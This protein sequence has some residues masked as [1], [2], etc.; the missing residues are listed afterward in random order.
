MGELEEGLRH[1]KHA[2]KLNPDNF[3]IINSLAD[4]YMLQGQYDSALVAISNMME[5]ESPHSAKIMG[6][7]EAIE[8]AAY[9][10]K[11]REALGLIE[12]LKELYLDDHD[13][14]HVAILNLIEGHIILNG[15]KDA[16]RVKEVIERNRQF[17]ES[18]TDSDYWRNLSVLCIFIGE[19]AA[20][21]R[22]L[23]NLSDSE[24]DEWEI[25]VHFFTSAKNQECARAD[26]HMVKLKHPPDGQWIIVPFVLAQCHVE[27][28]SFEEA[29]ELLH[30]VQATPDFDLDRAVCYPSSYYLL[31]R[32]QE[33]AGDVQL[34]VKR[35][36]K[37]ITLFKDADNDLVD[38]LDAR[39]RFDRLKEK[40]ML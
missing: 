28:G 31:G 16:A 9:T 19:Q 38:L 20:V 33:A 12:G 36:E 15:W 5:K 2:R 4:M 37:F 17:Q 24:R 22:I 39:E 10:G 21:E 8:L 3:A 26:S 23:A 25:Y 14:T 27:G 11:Y 1:L 40:P 29:I 18:I 6:H 13:T 30:E 32:A 35:Y 7:W 34:A